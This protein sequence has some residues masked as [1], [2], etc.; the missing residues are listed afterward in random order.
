M[1][2]REGGGRWEGGVP[3]GGRSGRNAR[4]VGGLRKIFDAGKNV[5]LLCDLSRASFRERAR[6]GAKEGPKDTD[7]GGGG[8]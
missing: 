1:G 7:T 6:K 4:E 2:G 3:S 5:I 8:T